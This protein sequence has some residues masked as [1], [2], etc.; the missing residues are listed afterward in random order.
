MFV[1]FRGCFENRKLTPEMH[2][3]P[4]SAPSLSW[5]MIQDAKISN[6]RLQSAYSY[7]SGMLQKI[8]QANN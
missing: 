4:I 1:Q 7:V 5:E 3:F 2:S 8:V 6:I